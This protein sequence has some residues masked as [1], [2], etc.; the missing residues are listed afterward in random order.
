VLLLRHGPEGDLHTGVLCLVTDNRISMTGFLRRLA[1]DE[2]PPER[3]VLVSD[4]RFPLDPGDRGAEYLDKLRERHGARLFEMVL[5][6]GEYAR[7]H[8][9]RAVV[10]AA[11]AGD[12]ELD[13]PGVRARPVSEQEVLASHRRRQRYLAQPLLRVLLELKEPGKEAAGLPAAAAVP[14]SP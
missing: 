11:R 14:T 6:V 8:A 5:T 13:E 12:L 1:E 3:L 9:L 7:L 2:Q 4:E 10:Q